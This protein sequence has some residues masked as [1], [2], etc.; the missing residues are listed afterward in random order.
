MEEKVTTLQIK[1]LDHSAILPKKATLNSA[2]YD[3]CANIKT[4][5]QINPNE[6]IKIKTGISM[7]FSPDCVGLI[8]ARS[9]LATNF[10]VTPANCV[11]VIDSD[12]RGE[13]IVAL[14]NSGQVSYT[15][16]PNERIAQFLLMPVFT[17]SLQEVEELDETVRGDGGFGSTN[18]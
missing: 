13:I 17:F 4:P 11:G 9:S 15:V 6:T 2:G 8:F 16:S 10:S 1:K 5:V 3:L 18:K 14:K 12:Y 7:A